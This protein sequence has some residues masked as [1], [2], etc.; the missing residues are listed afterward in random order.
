[1]SE[2]NVGNLVRVKGQRGRPEKWVISV[3]SENEA[4]IVQYKKPNSEKIISLNDIALYPVKA[5][6]VE[7]VV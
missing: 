6:K 2:F 1:M 4:K 7:E 5:E 3:M